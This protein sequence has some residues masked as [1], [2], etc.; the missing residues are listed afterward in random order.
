MT[1]DSSGARVRS[2]GVYYLAGCPPDDDHAV[3]YDDFVQDH[4]IW[5][6][7]VWPALANRIPYFE[8]IKVINSWAGHYAY[9]TLVQNAILGS[10]TEVENFIL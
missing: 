4:S 8:A 6:S 3:D 7:K 5:E 9:N 2:D 10:H 1:I